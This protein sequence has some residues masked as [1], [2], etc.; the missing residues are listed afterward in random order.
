MEFVNDNEIRFMT[1]EES[2]FYFY[3]ENTPEE[4]SIIDTIKEKSISRR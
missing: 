2:R 3:T 1:Q 4:Y